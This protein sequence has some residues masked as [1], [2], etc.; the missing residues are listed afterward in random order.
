MREDKPLLIIIQ[1]IEWKKIVDIIE[2]DIGEVLNPFKNVEF[3]F[4]AFDNT[5]LVSILAIVS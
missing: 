5:Y 1:Y 3:N 4:M 2:N